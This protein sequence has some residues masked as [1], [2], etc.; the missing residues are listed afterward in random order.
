MLWWS[1]QA[2]GCLLYKL[3]YFTLPFGESQVAICDG[4]FTIPDNS[5]YSQDVHCLISE[6]TRCL[7]YHICTKCMYSSTGIEVSICFTWINML[8]SAG[9][10]LEPDPD[11]RPDIYQVSYFAFRMARRECLV[12][13]VHVSN[14]GKKLVRQFCLENVVFYFSCLFRFWSL[15]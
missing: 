4:S 5:R 9:Y 15:A 6:C 11:R 1:A 12:P 7:K 10:M 8:C 3:C 13:N 14:D 2:M